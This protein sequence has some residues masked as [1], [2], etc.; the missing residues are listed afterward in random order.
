VEGAQRMIAQFNDLMHY[1]EVDEANP[2]RITTDCEVALQ[3]ALMQLRESIASSNATITHDPLPIIKAH[4][5]HLQLVFQELL[6]NAVKFRTTAPPQ[7]HVWAE[8][9]VGRWRF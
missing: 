2:E 3:N 4:S 7:V 6:D 5:A 9:E 8:H 1:L